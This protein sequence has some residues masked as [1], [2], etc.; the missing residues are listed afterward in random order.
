MQFSP[1][2]IA[3]I[4]LG[5]AIGAV[6]RHSVSVMMGSIMGSGFPWGTLTVNIVGSFLMGALLEI[7]ALKLSLSPEIRALLVTGFLGA[8][9]TFSTFSLDVATLYE[10]G[11]LGLTA[12]YIIVSVVVGISALFGAIALVRGILQ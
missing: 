7:S 12:L 3:S 5:G 10:R 11:N 2:F 8:F 4:A 1:L 6:A 9:T